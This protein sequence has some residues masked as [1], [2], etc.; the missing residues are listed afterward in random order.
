M[1]KIYLQ[2][3]DLQSIQKELECLKHIRLAVLKEEKVAPK[4]SLVVSR[5]KNTW[6]FY[7]RPEKDSPAKKYLSRKN[8]SKL[9]KV[10]AQK[11]YD[12]LFLMTLNKQIES[13]EKFLQEYSPESL[14]NTRESLPAGLKPFIDDLN[15]AKDKFILKWQDSAPSKN[16]FCPEGLKYSTSFGLKVRSKSEV[17]IAETLYSRSIPFKYEVPLK[18][19]GYGV[20]HPDFLC[21]NRRTLKEIIWEH[22]G[23]MDDSSYASNAVEKL[24]LYQNNGYINGKNLF[25]T[26]E[27]AKHPLDMKQISCGIDSFLA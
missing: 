13:L 22:F 14:L 10:L 9:I 2:T 17:M 19:R 12:A 27:T 20:V 1:D 16:T 4:G 24:L 21:L 15:D 18:L 6:Q 26:Q 8:D 5:W 25:C 23:K 3:I 7:L 11:K